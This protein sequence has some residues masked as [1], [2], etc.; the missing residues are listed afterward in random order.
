MGFEG[1]VRESGLKPSSVSNPPR[2]PAGPLARLQSPSRDLWLQMP[3]PHPWL[4]KP[5][6]ARAWPRRELSPSFLWV[7][8]VTLGS[9]ASNP[10]RQPAGPL[11]RLQSPFRD[12]W[13]QMPA[14][15][16]WLP[17]PGRLSSIV[18]LTVSCVWPERAD[19]T[20]LWHAGHL[21][22]CWRVS[23]LTEPSLTQNWLPDAAG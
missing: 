9:P 1:D 17:K 10:P 12:L 7:S 8:K 2:Q 18:F 16:P 5:G 4:P 21:C 6:L 23:A 19:H 20:T 15:Q 22:G 11:A 3:A 13:L 14:P